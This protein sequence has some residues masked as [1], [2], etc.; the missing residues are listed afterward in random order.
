MLNIECQSSPIRLN[1]ISKS[2]SQ[3]HILICLLL[4][5]NMDEVPGLYSDTSRRDKTCIV[6]IVRSPHKSSCYSEYNIM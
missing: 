4:K 5:A 6:R 3:K 1:S 2:R